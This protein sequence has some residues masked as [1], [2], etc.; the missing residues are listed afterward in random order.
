MRIKKR[1]LTLLE[2]MIV[3]T[4]IAI[5]AGVVG[6]NMKGSLDEGKAQNTKLAIEKIEEIL[7]LQAAIVDNTTLEDV[8]KNPK[9]YLE[10]SGLVKDAEKLLRDGWGDPFEISLSK[11]KIKIKSKRLDKF[12]EK[13]GKI[14]SSA[15]ADTKEEEEY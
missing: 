5:I 14:L 15:S 11:E 6:F 13:K 1:A 12:N 4:L 2:V 10:H 3:I 8:V 7:L 9:K